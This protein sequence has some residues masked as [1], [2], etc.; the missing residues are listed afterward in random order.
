MDNYKKN[1]RTGLR[2]QAP[3]ADKQILTELS[4]D[5]SLPDYQPE[6][7]RLLRV[8]ATVTPPEKYIGAGNAEFSGRVDYSVLYAGNDGS[9]YCASH[10]EDYSFSCPIE[11]PSDF[12][13][14]NGFVCDI[15]QMPEAVTGR[16]AAPRKLAIKC[17]LR[18]HVCILGT[19]LIEESITG[20]EAESLERLCATGESAV[21]FVGIGEPL[22]LGD[23]ILCEGADLRVVCAEGEVF[24][25][26]ATSGSGMVNCRGEVA[27]KLLCVHDGSTDAPTVQWRRI[28]F[29]QGVL[30]DGVEV[31][32]DACAHGTCTALHIT[33]EEGRILCEATVQLY[34]RAQRNESISYT[35]DIYSTAAAGEESYLSCTLPR[36]LKCINGNFSVNSTLTLEEAGIRSGMNAVDLTLVPII[37]EL[38]SEREKYYL[39]GRLRCQAVLSDGEESMAQEFE[40]PFR[41]ETEGGE[42]VTDYNATVTVISCRARMDGERIGVDAELAVCLCTR[43]SSTVRMLSA[44]SFDT[45]VSDAD[46]AYTV[47]YPSRED[48]LWSVAKRY[49]KSVSDISQRNRLAD[50]PAA[51]TKASLEGVK[52][53]LV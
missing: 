3:V 19:R 35:R 39:N 6:V 12:E 29:S 34:A 31:N 53:L 45:P 50:A 44:A 40:L 23:E 8:Y 32:C 41:Y 7:K 10:G 43:G 16:V 20:A 2:V 46:A 49:H 51:D 4:C 42:E 52:Y 48:T 13:L 30:T 37:G 17:R 15:E 27:V 1:D 28:P 36:A 21:R 9:L 11:V 14:N 24:V 22:V 26:E 33:V 47:C 25:S 18:S 5:L 38:T